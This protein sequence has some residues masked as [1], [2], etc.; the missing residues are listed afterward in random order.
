METPQP[1]NPKSQT[2]PGLMPMG[3][4]V[5]LLGTRQ[6]SHLGRERT[7]NSKWSAQIKTGMI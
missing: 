6:L 7:R 5:Q 3:I 1:P 4:Y 2:L